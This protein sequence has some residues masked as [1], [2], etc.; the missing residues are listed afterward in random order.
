ML[1]ISIDTVSDLL[2]LPN[3]A[4]ATK[5]VFRRGSAPSQSPLEGLATASQD[6]LSLLLRLCI[7]HRHPDACTRHGDLSSQWNRMVE[8]QPFQCE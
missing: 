4:P 1:P 8:D 3:C 2:S 7:R 6:F 5:G